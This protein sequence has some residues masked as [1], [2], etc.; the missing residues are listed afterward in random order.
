MLSDAIPV[1]NTGLGA[2]VGDQVE[3]KSVELYILPLE[4]PLEVEA[5]A[6]TYWPVLSDAIPVQLALGALLCV[7]VYDIYYIILANK[8]IELKIY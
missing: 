8:K 6:T 7:Q 1:Q 5:T 4:A 3:P 2:D